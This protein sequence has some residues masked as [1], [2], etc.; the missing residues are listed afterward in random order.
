M[1][2]TRIIWGVNFGSNNITAAFL[3]AK[4]LKK[5]FQSSAIKDAGVTLDFIEI[6]NEGDLF[7]FNG[8]RNASTFTID[9]Y[10]KE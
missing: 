1:P 10:T 8:D 6:G 9:E 2:G 5:A 4:S 3:A 7:R